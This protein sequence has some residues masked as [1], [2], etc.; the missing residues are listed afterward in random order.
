M[1]KRCVICGD[2]AEFVIKNSQDAY[3]RECALDCFSDLSFLQ[4]VEEQAKELKEIVKQ[5]M[6]DE[7]LDKD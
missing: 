2:G 1:G 5:R 6:E 4:K 3:C 7:L